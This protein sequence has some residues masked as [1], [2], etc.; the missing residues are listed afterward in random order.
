MQ[1]ILIRTAKIDD[2]DN[3]IILL[4]QL[5]EMENGVTIN[6]EKQRKGIELIISN[7]LSNFLI[8]E[9]DNKIVGICSVQL[10]V[11]TAEG[12]YSAWIED[13]YIEKKYRKLGI[14]LKI[15]NFIENWSKEKDIK[16]I[17][18]LCDENNKTAHKLYKKF[19]MQK[20]NWKCWFKKI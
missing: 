10:F 1:N 9:I 19:A 5:F 3:I 7:E 13:L 2:I 15:L 12:G 6:E 14:A 17:Q 8:A 16:K 18:L 11:S 20:T 4:K